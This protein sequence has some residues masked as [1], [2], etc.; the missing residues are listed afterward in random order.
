MIEDFS[1]AISGKPAWLPALDQS[2]YVAKLLDQ[3]KGFD[4]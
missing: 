1:D 3:I 2:L 4:A